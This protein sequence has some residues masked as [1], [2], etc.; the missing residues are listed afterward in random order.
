MA[1]RYLGLQLPSFSSQLHKF[2]CLFYCSC[3]Y[4]YEN[5]KISINLKTEHQISGCFIKEDLNE[6]LAVYYFSSL[7][8]IAKILSMEEDK[9]VSL[10]APLG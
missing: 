6:Y 8:Q 3:L 7:E 1:T 9:A 5:M 10:S 2:P 4:G